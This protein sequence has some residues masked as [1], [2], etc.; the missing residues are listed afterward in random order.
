[1]NTI[2]TKTYKSLP[3]NEKEA[4]RYA[5]CKIPDEET[6]KLL[7]SSIK[8]IEDKLTYK[9]CY[10]VFPLNIKDDLCDFNVFSVKSSKLAKNLNGCSDVV[11]FAA[12]IGVGIDRLISKYGK[13]S[14]SKSVMISALGSER[15]EALCDKFNKDFEFENEV[16]LKPRFSPGFGD[17]SLMIQKDIFSVLDCPRKIGLSLNDSLLMSPTKS[18]TAF[19]GI[20]K[21]KECL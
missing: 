4:L 2:I 15:I 21:K 14:P 9:V 12:T 6:L 13:I 8:E 3:F 11:I 16:S 10:G 1:M 19:V 20:I 17:L 18:V 5:G 7:N